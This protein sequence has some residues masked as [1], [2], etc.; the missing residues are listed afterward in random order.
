MS[1]FFVNTNRTNGTNKW[2][3]AWFD[4]QGRRLTQKPTKAGLYIN[5]GKK[6]Y[7]K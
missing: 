6:Q 5:N 2:A 3:G 1:L 4:L 7:V